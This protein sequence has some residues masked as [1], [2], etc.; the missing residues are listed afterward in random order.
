M[1]DLLTVSQSA[2]IVTNQPE[3]DHPKRQCHGVRSP[4]D[5]DFDFCTCRYDKLVSFLTLLCPVEPPGMQRG[6][7]IFTPHA[8]STKSLFLSS[9]SISSGKAL[10]IS[11]LITLPTLLSPIASESNTY[12][13]SE[14][15][16]TSSIFTHDLMLE[17]A[18][19]GLATIVW[20][21]Y[22]YLNFHFPFQSVSYSMTFLTVLMYLF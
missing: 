16:A 14:D 9:S 21:P 20:H 12:Q 11:T 8:G 2:S 19:E 13:F 15:S 7:L 1:D 10:I 5:I 4:P 6:S 17:Q 3:V 22:P 18:C